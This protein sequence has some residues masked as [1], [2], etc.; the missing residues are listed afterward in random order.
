M[1]LKLSAA[2]C[3]ESSILREK[4]ILLFCSL[5]PPQAAGNALAIG[6]NSSGKA[7]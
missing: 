5:T 2:S 6:F 4:D 3:G 7:H 1:I